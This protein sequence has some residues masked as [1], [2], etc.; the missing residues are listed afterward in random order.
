MTRS[1]FPSPIVI[2]SRDI[3]VLVRFDNSACRKCGK[4]LKEGDMA[5][6]TGI[7]PTKYYHKEC[8]KQY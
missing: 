6:R 3:D 4:H 5:I 8:F 2:E 1:F 7:H